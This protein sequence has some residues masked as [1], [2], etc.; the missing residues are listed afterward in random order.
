MLHG[1]NKDEQTAK[2]E[3]RD[4]NAPS[5]SQGR[6]AAAVGRRGAPHG[7]CQCSRGAGEFDDLIVAERV[8]REAS[9]GNG[10]AYGLHE[11]DLGVPD[12]DRHEDQEDVLENAC[13][14]H[15]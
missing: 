1:G 13:E 15:D 7:G 11:G 14:G 6:G 8:V 2:D 4:Q 5:C 12:Q 3:R 10:V 9:Q